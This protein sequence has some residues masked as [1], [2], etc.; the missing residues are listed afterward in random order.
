MTLKRTFKEKGKNTFI[1]GIGQY[2]S[3][4]T[5]LQS[6]QYLLKQKVTQYILNFD[7]GLEA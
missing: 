6:H 3:R 5:V 2:M 1:T 7:I 4:K